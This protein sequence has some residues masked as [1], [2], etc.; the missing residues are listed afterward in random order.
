VTLRPYRVVGSK[1][2]ARA[3]LVAA[4]GLA[5]VSTSGCRLWKPKDTSADKASV[6]GDND[7]SPTYSSGLNMCAAIRGNGNYIFAHFGSLAR[8][9]EEYGKID[10]AAG[11]SSASITPF[12][13]ESLLLS[14]AL[15]GYEGQAYNLRLALLLKSLM[16]YV[17]ALETSDEGIAIKLMMALYAEYKAGGIEAIDP[18]EAQL[19]EAKLKTLLQDPIYKGL[20]NPNILKMLDGTDDLGFKSKELKLQEIK[21]AVGAIGAFDAS[22]EKILFRE[23]VIHFP[24]LVA[25]IDRIANFYADRGPADQAQLKRFVEECGGEASRGKNWDEVA[26]LPMAGEGAPSCGAFFEGV[27]KEYRKG[28]T[29]PGYVPEK[30]RMNDFVGATI[31]AFLIGS[32]IKGGAAIDALKAAYARYY[33]GEQPSYELKHF[34]AVKL[35]YYVDPKFGDLEAKLKALYPDDEKTKRFLAMNTEPVRWADVLPYTAI[36]PG[37]SKVVITAADTA[38]AGGWPDLFPVQL[39]KAAGCANTIYVTR[40]G[41]ES[42]FLIGSRPVPEGHEGRKGVAELLG[43]DAPTQRRYFD[44]T[45][46]AP[47]SAFKTAARDAEAVWCTDWNRGTSGDLAGL[48]KFGYDSEITPRSD[49]FKAKL[50][51]KRIAGAPGCD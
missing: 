27:V 4:L 8:I 21:A 24:A 34:D 5:V 37:L 48:F 7:S 45:E 49:F 6:K 15:K 31:P 22:D 2:L 46:T 17:K 25:L 39:L 42:E 1:S 20:I 47:F 40:R 28:V 11:G 33:A 16:G 3:A 29:A 19:L 14:P 51:D 38:F 43:I 35:G 9:V 18:A 36:E 23:G 30:P 13:Y 32:V 44:L 10:A 26:A 12:L 41:A 50:A